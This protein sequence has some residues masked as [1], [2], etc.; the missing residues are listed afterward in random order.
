MEGLK[1][2]DIL[3]DALRALDDLLVSEGQP[4]IEIR[5]IGGFALAF[6]NIRQDGLTRDIDTITPDY[7]ASH[8]KLISRVADSLGLEDDWLNN[9]AV[10]TV[11]GLTSRDA[12]MRHDAML[13]AHYE[14]APFDFK[15]IDLQVADLGTLMRSKLYA[16]DAISLGARGAKDAQDLEAIL[17]KMGFGDIDSAIR[18]MAWLGDP[19]FA[20]AVDTMRRFERGDSL[21]AYED[22]DDLDDF[23]N[24]ILSSYENRSSDSE[25]LGDAYWDDWSY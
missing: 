10:A 19:E 11:D 15:K 2:L 17:H 1:T 18:S 14:E 4:P 6:R 7:P 9:D 24:D 20:H 25:A 13:D 21:V 3:I 12:V 16:V 23:L 22:P 5:A 8:V